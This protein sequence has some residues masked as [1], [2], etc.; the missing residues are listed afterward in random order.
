MVY[1]NPATVYDITAY[2]GNVHVSTVCVFQIISL[3][4]NFKAET[5]TSAFGM[6]TMF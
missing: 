5:G 2:E 6:A 4:I 3:T 1:C